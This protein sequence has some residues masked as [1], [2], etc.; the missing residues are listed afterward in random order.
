MTDRRITIYWRGTL[1]APLLGALIGYA[2]GY[3]ALILTGGF[4]IIAI[5]YV[6][7]AV[8]MWWLIGRLESVKAVLMLA[9]AAPIIFLLFWFVFVALLA[10]FEVLSISW[11][12]WFNDA[13]SLLFFILTLGYAYVALLSAVFAIW[14]MVTARR[15]ANH[16]RNAAA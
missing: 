14:R 1:F 12:D 9:V 5:P 13:L 8:L 15:A 16:S 4:F 2:I 6:P 3:Y 11:S 7:F 10:V